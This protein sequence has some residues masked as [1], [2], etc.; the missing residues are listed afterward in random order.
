MSARGGGETWPGRS[1]LVD[2]AGRATPPTANTPRP[3]R[4]SAPFSAS[5]ARKYADVPPQLEIS[6]R[7]FKSTLSNT[8]IVY[9]PRFFFKWK[10]CQAT[11]GPELACFTDKCRIALGLRPA[12][13]GKVGYGNIIEIR[14]IEEGSNARETSYYEIKHPPPIPRVQ[15]VYDEMSAYVR[16]KQNVYDRG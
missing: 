9:S 6:S 8:I 15:Y 16:K 10:A 14:Y 1:S 5:T 7:Q 4:Q 13:C 12:C 2:L 3:L 11:A